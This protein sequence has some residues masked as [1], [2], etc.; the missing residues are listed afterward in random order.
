MRRTDRDIVIDR[1]V[2][3]F[4]P[5]FIAPDVRP[6]PATAPHPSVPQFTE[7]DFPPPRAFERPRNGTWRLVVG[8]LLISAATGVAT[9]YT[10]DTTTVF[11]ARTGLTQSAATPGTTT[12]ETAAAQVLPSVVQV[13]AGRS[14]GSGFA[15]DGA[16]H[17][18][19]NHHVIDGQSAISIRLASGDR[20]RATVVGSDPANDIAV[21]RVDGPPPPIVQLGTSAPL[22]IGQPVLAVG[23]PLGLSGTVTAGIIS[24]L[25]RQS[26]G[27]AGGG[28]MIQTDASINPG[29]SGGPLVNLDGQV[30]GVNT[31]I[32][33]LGGEGSGNI[34]IGFS[35]PIDRVVQVAERLIASE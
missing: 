3:R 14:T 33:T 18:V 2:H 6:T 35:V 16:G 12:A 29:N 10:I 23:S 22:Q 13:V 31:L 15:I 17:I 19:T 28:P 5:E 7:P 34:G 24:A 27:S 21:L 25:D 1:P 8:C 30:I 26:R 32:A 4:R 11:Q 20:V 9:A